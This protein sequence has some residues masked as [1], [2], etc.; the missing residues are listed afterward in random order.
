[1]WSATSLDIV[2]S[3]LQPTQEWRA[4]LL[5]HPDL[6][7]QRLLQDASLNYIEAKLCIRSPSF[8][9][10]PFSEPL[11]SSPEFPL[12]LSRGG[13][14][15]SKLLPECKLQAAVM[16]A[17]GRLPE[18]PSPHWAFGRSLLASYNPQ[19]SR[20]PVP[21]FI[22]ETHL[23]KVRGFHENFSITM[24]SDACPHFT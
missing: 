11:P 20:Q 13:Q 16:P 12:C 8:P 15:E 2:P 10:L 1:M 6:W 17:W 18:L 23:A 5:V 3:S 22:M 9:S 21:T 14:G 4:T 7:D 24:T 19:G